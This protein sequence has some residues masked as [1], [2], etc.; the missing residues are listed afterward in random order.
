MEV[1]QALRVSLDRLFARGR[2]QVRENGTGLAGL[3][4]L[5]YEVR[6]KGGSILLHLWSAERNVVRRVISIALDA[7][8]SIEVEVARLGQSDTQRFA[9]LL[10]QVKPPPGRIARE[11]FRWRFQEM[12]AQQFPDDKL[13]SL[14]TSADLKRSLSGSYARGL[15]RVGPYAWAILGAAPDE[16]AATYDGVLTAGLLWLDC[17]RVSARGKTVTG[18]RLFIPRG[19]TRV[20]AFRLQALSPST[21]VE[22]YEYDT[23]NWHARRVDPRDL[24]N[25]NTWLVPRRDAEELLRQGQSA[26]ERI[27]RMAPGAIEAAPVPGTQEIAFRFRGLLFARW[28]PQAVFYGVD[29]NAGEQSA[30]RQ[31]LLTPERQPDFAKLVRLLEKYRSPVIE[32]AEARHKFY[33]AQPERWLETLIAAD[34]GRV[35]A[36]LDPRFLYEQ[37]PALSEGER[38]VM[39]LIGVT[40][41]GRL[42]VIELKA[43]E[44]LHHAR[45]EFTRFGYFPGIAL[46]PRPPLLF[47]VAPAIRFHPATDILLR[48]INSEI[49]VS[50]VGVSETWRRGLRVV[51]RQ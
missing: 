6:E 50:R 42:V 5:Q 20:T 2:V 47:L 4:G 7:P 38:G 46:D 19:T 24:G 8:T 18:L 31:Q 29:R 40:R 43:S 27:R 49:E 25:V 21:N 26:I 41:S 36:R 44:D 39:D 10:E 33:R 1:A 28:T 17:T 14:T 3:E 32:G 34:P 45:D 12:L 37:V 22:L 13:A 35:D 16:T 23:G 48:Y 11:Q 30:G 15:L 9:I 51:L